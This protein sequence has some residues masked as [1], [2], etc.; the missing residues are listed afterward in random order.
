MG[1]ENGQIKPKGPTKVGHYAFIVRH[2]TLRAASDD[3]R[4]AVLDL[5]ADLDL[6]A[7]RDDPR[8]L[9]PRVLP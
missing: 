8:R 5:S 6:S 1:R 3:G 9:M 4:V 2:P 7:V